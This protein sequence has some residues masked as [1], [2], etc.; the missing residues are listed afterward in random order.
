MDVPLLHGML[1]CTIFGAE[2]LVHEQPSHHLLGAVSFF[3]FAFSYFFLD[4]ACFLYMDLY[5]F[6]I[7]WFFGDENI[8][9]FKLF[10][11]NQW[12]NSVSMWY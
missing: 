10:G 5:H 7:F 4:L 12:I 3:F 6:C 2:N 8:H 11:V 9:I 1:H